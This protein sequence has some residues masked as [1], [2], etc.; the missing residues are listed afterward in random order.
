L[1]VRLFLV[2][3]TAW[4]QEL[5]SQMVNFM[6]LVQT[7][8]ESHKKKLKSLNSYVQEQ[9]AQQVQSLEAQRELA[10]KAQQSQQEEAEL[11]KVR[12]HSKPPIVVFVCLFFQAT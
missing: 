11:M 12:V 3:L 8:G 7:F 6:E 10:K 1:F 2:K 4:Q 5:D 9:T